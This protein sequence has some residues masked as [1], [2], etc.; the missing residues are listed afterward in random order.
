MEGCIMMDGSMMMDDSM[1]IMMCFIML[2][3]LILVIVVVGVTVYL[4]VRLLMRKSRVEDRPLMIL[5]ERYVQ[6]EI[7]DEEFE[8]KRKLL[9]NLDSVK[10]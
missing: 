4:V 3:C 5:K 8:H 6:G 2:L 7:N 1:M 10:Q 9:N